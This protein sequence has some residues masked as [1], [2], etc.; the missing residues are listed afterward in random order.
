MRTGE[1]EE[2]INDVCDMFLFMRS[3]SMF[4]LVWVIVFQAAWCCCAHGTSAIGDKLL[5]QD[6][7]SIVCI[8]VRVSFVP[9]MVLCVVL[10]LCP[11][12]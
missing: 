9:S 8:K 2:Q 12:V 4:F 5:D 6:H 3:S 11:V 7:P 1:Y 10:C